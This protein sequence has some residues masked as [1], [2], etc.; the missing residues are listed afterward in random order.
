M[1]VHA[2]GRRPRR[3]PCAS[4]RRRPSAGRAR[5][6]VPLRSSTASSPAIRFYKGAGEHRHARRAP[7]DHHRQRCSR[8]GH[9]HRRDG[10]RAG[11]RSTFATPVPI[12]AEHRPTSPR[13]SPR[14]A[15]T[16]STTA[17]SRDRASTGRRCTRSADGDGRPQR[18]L[19]RTAPSGFPTQTFNATNYWVDVVFTTTAAAATRRRRPSPPRRPTSGRHR[20]GRDRQRHR[21]VQ[22]GDGRRAIDLDGTFELRDPAGALVA[23]DRHLRTPA[24]RTATLD[25]DAPRWRPS[26]TYTATVRGGAPTRAS[27]TSPATRWRPTSPGRSRRPPR[28]TAAAR[29]PARSSAATAT[30]GTA[31]ADRHRGGRARR[32]VP[33]RRQRHVTAIRF[34]K[35]ARNTGTHV[36][37]LWTTTGTLLAH[38]HLHRRD[39]RRAGS[40]R[41]SPSPV[42]IT[43]NTTYVASY[44]APVGGYAVDARLLHRRPP[45]GRRCTRRR[46]ARTAE[47]RLSLRRQRLP[48]PDVLTP[49]TTGWTWCS[50]RP[51]PGADTTPPTVT[52]TSPTTGAD[53]RGR[54]RQRH[55]DVQRADGPRVDL[56]VNVRAPQPGGGAHGRHGHL[57]RRHA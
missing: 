51:R 56:D 46:R 27:R 29:A 42:A 14:T 21:D 18:R 39:R 55:R 35:G 48:R 8:T 45:T 12:T 43:A 32:E 22:R 25:A 5:R 9:L 54:H 15:A 10:A 7:V 20:R 52:A 13:T 6:E 37:H 49:R 28:A 11:S 38:G 2:S 3:R 44:Y 24:T 4:D 34:Y 23:A 47:R 50:P 33:R 40:R 30:P 41:A 31:S 53:R 57:E 36:G 26:T 1:P 17:T 16:R 19:P